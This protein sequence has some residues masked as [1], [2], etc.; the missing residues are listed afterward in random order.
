VERPRPS[1]RPPHPRLYCWF[2]VFGCGSPSKG[3]HSS[4]ARQC[5]RSGR[6]CGGVPPMPPNRNVPGCPTTASCCICQGGRES[7]VYTHTY[8]QTSAKPGVQFRLRKPFHTFYF[9]PMSR[10][11]SPPVRAAVLPWMVAR[12]NYIPTAALPQANAR[13]TALRQSSGQSTCCPPFSTSTGAG[14]GCYCSPPACSPTSAGFGH[15]WPPRCTSIH[16][17]ENPRRAWYNPRSPS[18]PN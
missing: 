11:T 14:G 1:P 3:S 16:R 17:L 13:S 9:V 7:C 15:S 18:F 12:P 2:R 4:R 6:S 8:R 5:H 10:S